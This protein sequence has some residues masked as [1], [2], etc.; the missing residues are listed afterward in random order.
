MPQNYDIILEITAKIITFATNLLK[1]KRICY[2]W[3]Y[4]QK[5]DCLKTR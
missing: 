4:N 5:A 3:Q 2:V 1:I